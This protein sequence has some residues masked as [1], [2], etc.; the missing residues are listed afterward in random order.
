MAMR[1]SCGW[2]SARWKESWRVRD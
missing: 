1:G 2:R